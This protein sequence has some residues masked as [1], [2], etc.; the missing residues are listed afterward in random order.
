[1]RAFVTIG[2]NGFAFVM[3]IGLAV[4][5]AA[6]QDNTRNDIIRQLRAAAGLPPAGNAGSAQF[7]RDLELNDGQGAADTPRPATFDAIQFENNSDQLKGSAMATIATIADTLQSPEFLSIR[8]AVVGHANAVGDPA[9]NLVLSQRRAA[10]VVSAL[11][12]L[13][14]PARRLTQEGQGQSK[15][16]PGTDGREAI[17]RRVEFWRI[18]N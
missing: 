10:A 6:A 5:P 18:P 8:F 3:A 1:M 4:A 9:R 12:S 17:N 13:G 15:P 2:R 7:Q 11:V 14:V 16:I